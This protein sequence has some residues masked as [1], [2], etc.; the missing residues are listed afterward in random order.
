MLFKT[1]NNLISAI[2]KFLDTIDQGI[3]VFKEGVNN[4][5]NK[6][7]SKFSEKIELILKLES[8]AD[9]TRRQIENDLY[10]HSLLP[11]FRGDVLVLLE[12][13]DDIIDTAKEDLLQFDVEGPQIPLEL[14][15]DFSKLTDASV[16][17]VESLIPAV[18]AYFNDV[19]AVKDKLHRV[20]FYEKESDKL[21]DNIKRRLFKELHDLK[22]SEKIHLRYFALHIE[23]ISDV[24]EEV[25]N[26]L[27]I[28]SI[29]RSL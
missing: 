29:K 12:K 24:A 11:Q 26:L 25:A 6:E 19:N 17:S 5:L 21:A 20:Y 27:A 9:E 28:M 4:Y 8:Q 7:E 16:L 22:L 14:N 18:R 23:N 2:N 15:D 1:A 3:L 10:I 13:L